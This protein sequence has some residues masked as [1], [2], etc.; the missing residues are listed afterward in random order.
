[1]PD[2]VTL[3]VMLVIPSASIGD[4]IRPAGDGPLGRIAVLMGGGNDR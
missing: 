2:V 3:P 1:M 4:M